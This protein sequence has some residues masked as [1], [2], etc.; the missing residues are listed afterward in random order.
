MGIKNILLVTELRF[1]QDFLNY[2][3]RWDDVE[4]QGDE[5]FDEAD[6]DKLLYR[7]HIAARAA[8]YELNALVESEIYEA[9]N[10]PWQASNHKG[11]KTLPE[12]ISSG[13]SFRSMKMVEDLRIKDAISLIEGEY[14]INIS[15][16]PG[17]VGVFQ[18]RESVNAFKHRQ[19]FVDFRKQFQDQI[20]LAEKY[21]VDVDTATHAISC[22]KDF[23]QALRKLTGR[24]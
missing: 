22:T 13:K 5:N 20:K 19:G 7:Q 16:L 4:K 1:L 18:V 15:E 9:A 3:C 23:V 12:C 21:K 2:C 17:Y 24:S 8:Y 11:P 6:F 10:K 14:Q